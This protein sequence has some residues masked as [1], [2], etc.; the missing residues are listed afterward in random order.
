MAVFLPDSPFSP[1]RAFLDISERL[2]LLRIRTCGNT[3]LYK[4]LLKRSKDESATRTSLEK[5][6]IFCV[7]SVVI[8]IIPA[9]S[10]TYFVK[11]GRNLLKLNSK[12]PYPS[13]E[14]EINVRRCLFKFSIKFGILTSQ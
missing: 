11:C 7:L 13:L 4:G 5:E 9:H 10:P 14:G 3:F 6:L 12:R 1:L 2:V 8:A